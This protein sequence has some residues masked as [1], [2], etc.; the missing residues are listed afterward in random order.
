MLKLKVE[1][2]LTTW[3][4]TPEYNYIAFKLL[5]KLLRTRLIRQ[6]D[7]CQNRDRKFN[8]KVVKSMPFLRKAENNLA[9]QNLGFPYWFKHIFGTL[10]R[11]FF[12]DLAEK[13]IDYVII[14]K[15]LQR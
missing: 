4:F 15:H 12:A 8:V 11:Q 6:K 9:L 3:D 7:K 5:S 2:P 13:H 1:K 14:G 10:V